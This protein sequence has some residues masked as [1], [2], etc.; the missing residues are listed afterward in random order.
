MEPVPIMYRIKEKQKGK[1]KILDS[2]QIREMLL[3]VAVM[4]QEKRDEL[5]RLDS[6]I[7]DGDLRM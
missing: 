3:A 7:G 1:V 2:K 6:V 5:A 4:F